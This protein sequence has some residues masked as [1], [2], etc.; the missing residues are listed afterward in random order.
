MRPFNFGPPSY[1][2]NQIPIPPRFPMFAPNF[3]RTPFTS[4]MPIPPQIPPQIPS[5]FPSQFPSQLPT[6]FP[7]QLPTQ[8]VGGAPRLE[9]FLA[10]ANSLFTNAQKF[11]PY[12]QQAAPMFKNLPALWRLYKGFKGSPDDDVL[13][14]STAVAP[15]ERRG[16]RQRQQQEQQEQQ[17]TP[18]KNRPSVPMIF[19]P[20]FE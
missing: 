7:T 6:Q 10:G 17:R 4:Q 8:A 15:V 9:S 16:R 5:Q 18:L 3:M 2:M 12:V 1:T 14:S 13:D 11:T 20:P 19:Q